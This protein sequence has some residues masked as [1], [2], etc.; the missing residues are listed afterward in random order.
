MAKDVT[1]ANRSIMQPKSDGRGLSSQHLQA[2][3]T[4]AGNVGSKGCCQSKA[5]TLPRGCTPSTAQ[6]IM[7]QSLI[8]LWQHLQHMNLGKRRDT[9]GQLCLRA[10]LKRPERRQT[11]VSIHE[12][13]VSI[14]QNLVWISQCCCAMM[15]LCNDAANFKWSCQSQMVKD[16]MLKSNC[17]KL[18]RVLP[19]PNPTRMLPPHMAKE[20]CQSQRTVRW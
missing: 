16:D 8:K 6:H 1:Q 14:H 4:L 12:T 7:K 3:N 5:L 17:Q 19:K 18:K 15:L 9:Q 10:F 13:I 11:I 2:A 20:R